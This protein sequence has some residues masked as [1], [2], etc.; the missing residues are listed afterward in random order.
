M[1]NLLTTEE[2]SFAK[3]VLVIV[4]NGFDISHGIKSKYEDFRDFLSD[5]DKKNLLYFLD[6]FFNWTGKLWSDFENTLGNYDEELILNECRPDEPIDFDHYMRSTAA[7]EDS[8]ATFLYPTLE[9]LNIEFSNWVNSISLDDIDRI[10][11]NVSSSSLYLSFN[12]LET[13]EKLYLIPTNRVFH[14]HG[15]RLKRDKYIFG[16]NNQRVFHFTDEDDR[17]SYEEEALLD[18]IN[19]MNEF[20][21]PY[22]QNIIQCPLFGSCLQQIQR[23][24]V[25]GHS[26]SQIDKPYFE[27]IQ[28]YTNPHIRWRISY[29][30]DKGIPYLKQKCC[31]LKIYNYELFK[32]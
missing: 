11:D 2:Q 25:V 31:D 21:K 19:K 20:I 18:I 15:S 22:S 26:L 30:D 28:K 16:H 14:I 3:N 10:F 8:P 12:Y 17:P 6:T 32:L 29:H 7:I 23:I 4:G 27:E 9:E 5:N 13:L 24:V 1:C